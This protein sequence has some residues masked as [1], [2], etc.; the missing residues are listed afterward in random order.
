LNPNSIIFMKSDGTYIQCTCMSEFSM[1]SISWKQ[2][3]YLPK[4]LQRIRSSESG[5]SV[6]LYFHFLF[7]K[8]NI[9]N[10]C[11]SDGI[12]KDWTRWNSKPWLFSS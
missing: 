7:K 8:W 10:N 1:F 3:Q 11:F 6:K 9:W 12:W 5:T 2:K 4:S